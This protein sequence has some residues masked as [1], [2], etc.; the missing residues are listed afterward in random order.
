MA[1]ER[2][3]FTGA[4]TETTITGDINS[5]DTTISIA[6]ATGWPTGSQ[7]KFFVV[8]DPGT[9]SEEKVLVQSRSGTTLTVA[10][11]ADR[12]ADDT[13]AASHSSGATIYCSFSAQDADEANYWVAELAGAATAANDLIIADGDNSLSKITKGSNSTVLRVDSGGTLAYGTITSAMIA[14]GTIATDDIADDAV[15]SAKIADGTIATANI[16]DAAVDEDKLATSVAGD[17][18]AGGG[19]TALSVTVDDSTLA[20]VT[21]TLKVKDAGIT[22]TQIATSVAGDGLAGGGGSALSVNVDDSTIEVATDTLQVKADGIGIDHILLDEDPTDDTDATRK[23]YV[24]AKVPTITG[25]QVGTATTYAS[26]STVATVTITDPGYNIELWG[27]A[28]VH[29]SASASPSWWQLQILVDGTLQ[30]TLVVPFVELAPG[31]GQSIGVPMK[32]TTHST[33]TNCS[34]TVKLV[35][36]TGTITLGAPG[37][38]GFDDANYCEFQ[39][40]KNG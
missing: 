31:I 10:S 7:G 35:G 15:T 6:S 16:A 19:G 29:A 32:R 36:S 2:R 17:G 37:G 14:D 1:Y 27:W 5:S 11:A 39:W 24:D 25:A 21:D 23:S 33:G 30:S 26:G 3:D 28:T 34:I 22:G 12:G 4:P 18:L 40:R 8:I 9:A 13:S 20:I 38:A